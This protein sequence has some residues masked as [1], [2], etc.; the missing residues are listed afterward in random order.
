MFPDDLY[1]L[2]PEISLAGIAV[3]VILLDLVLED[4][5][6]LAVA[7]LLGLAL[8][9]GF[10]IALWVNIDGKPDNVLIGFNDLLVVDYFSLFFKFLI[11]G[12][13][14]LVILSSQEYVSRFRRF[15]GEYY[16][17]VLT[18]SVGMMLLAATRELIS[19][20]IALELSSLSLAALVAFLRDARS[21]EASI[22]FLIL[23][24]L[25]SGVMLYGMALVFGLTGSTMLSDISGEIG[26]LGQLVDEPALLLGVIFIV[27]GF[28]FKIST[29]PF[30]MWV[31]DVYEGAPTPIV[32]FLSVASKAAG[33][34]VIL[35]V[36]NEAFGP[37]LL[38]A[39]WS[40][41]FAVL[42]AASM[43]IGN[44]IAIAQKNIKR[45][46][47]YSTIAQAGFIMVGLA[48]I[49]GPGTS[50][51]LFYLVAYAATNLAAFFAIIAIS[52]KTGSDLIDGY[53]GMSK[54][55]PLL[56]FA[57]TFSLLSLIGIP[58]TA[59]FWAKINIFAAAV[60]SDLVWLVIVGVINS[61]ISAYYYLRIV[62]AMYFSPPPSEER[63]AFAPAA[64]TAL[65]VAS[66]GVLF[67][68]VVPRYL[69]EIIDT[70]V[71]NFG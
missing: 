12:I 36:F 66:I 39:E 17:L 18:A 70:A 71:L 30:Q 7:S 61:V 37:P 35:R 22:K 57:L 65:A 69:L 43:F 64:T 44:L 25:S 2:S 15:Q 24:A 19:I 55:N 11:V 49:N 26:S 20:Y 58:P 34:A 54:R 27:A 51:V 67:L 31:P 5:R 6:I 63:L 21:T 10:S 48:A 53:A 40:F 38:M 16:A 52:S 9:V 13:A 68:G 42:A 8:P 59:G 33:F 50:G 23:S 28:G 45:L 46:M 3:I 56:A 32:A 47:G 29:V 1:L 14:A 41:L 4:K 62:R 60:D